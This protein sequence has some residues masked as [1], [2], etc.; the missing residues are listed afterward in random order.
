[1]TLDV[2]STQTKEKVIKSN[3]DFDQDSYNLIENYSTQK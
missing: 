1:M 3:I 2:D